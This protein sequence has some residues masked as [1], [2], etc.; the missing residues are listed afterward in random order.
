[1]P[2]TIQKSISWTFLLLLA[3]LIVGWIIKDQSPDSFWLFFGM[4]LGSAFE[5][6]RIAIR[7]HNKKKSNLWASLLFL[8]NAVLIILSVLQPMLL[9]IAAGLLLPFTIVLIVAQIRFRRV[10][11]WE[12]IGKE[13]K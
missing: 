9:G 5:A 1:M 8:A 12:D 3:C 7:K 4:A 10:I 11:S 2:T 6:I 13:N